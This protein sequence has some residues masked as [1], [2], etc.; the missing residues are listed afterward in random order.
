MNVVAVTGAGGMIGRHLVETLKAAA[1]HVRILLLP[2]EPVPPCCDGAA[3]Y[4]GDIRRPDDLGGFMDGADTVFHLAAL[5]GKDAGTLAESRAVNVVGTHNLVEL[6]KAHGI[7]RFVLLST[8]C[9]YG[10]YSFK[11]EILDESAPHTPI[12]HPYDRTKTESEE[13]VA[14]EEPTRLP[15]SIL[16]VPVVLGGVH[17]ANK[18]NLM[19]HIRMTR[20]GFIPC[21][22]NECSWANFVYAGDVAAALACLGAHPRA[23]GEVFIFNEAVPLN[24]LFDW[25]ARELNVAVRRVSVPGFALRLAASAHDRLAVLANRRRFSSEKLHSLLGYSPRVGLQEGLRVTI[26]Y[27]RRTGLIT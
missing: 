8:C 15:W 2:N 26:S 17:T 16:Q 21:A 13:L 27:Y 7:R 18:P 12:D 1:G 6:A 14:A 4:R 23:A 22:L 10:L 11:D 19:A 5:V 9:V 20:A 3:V 24:N 25:I